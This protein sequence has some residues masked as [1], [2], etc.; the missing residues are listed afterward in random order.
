[1]LGDVM[2]GSPFGFTEALGV[3][4][5]ESAPL[6]GAKGVAESGSLSGTRAKLSAVLLV[7]QK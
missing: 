5:A 7:S 3:G 1:M 6:P 2:E 4:G